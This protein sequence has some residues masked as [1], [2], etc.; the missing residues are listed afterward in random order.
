MNLTVHPSFL[1]HDDPKASLAFWCGVL[2]FEVGDD[3]GDDRMR[4]IT[5]GP[6]APILLAPPA[7]GPGLTDDE[8]RTI[9]E[10]M[11]KGSCGW[12]LPAT[13]NLEDIFEKLGTGGA[14][15]VQE[16]TDQ[17]CAVRDPAGNLVRVQERR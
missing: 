4:W 13:S 2:G 17:S 16:P 9:G 8:R 11:T 6:D 15:I 14:G 1:P 12:I 10:M 7:A 5:V 3:I